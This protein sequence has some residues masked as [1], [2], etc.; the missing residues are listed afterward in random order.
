MGLRVI[1][2]QRSRERGRPVGP[3]PRDRSLTVAARFSADW[4]GWIAL[5][6]VVF[7]GFAYALMVLQARAPR[8][9]HGIGT[10]ARVAARLAHPQ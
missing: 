4:R 10:L 3:A 6:W 2:A 1:G 9:L 5:A 8:I 7:W